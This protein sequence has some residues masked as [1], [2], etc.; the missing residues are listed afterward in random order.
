MSTFTRLLRRVR[1]TG[2][3]PIG[4]ELVPEGLRAVQLEQ[5]GAELALVA[6]LRAGWPD[7]D[8]AV[9]E[10]TPALRRFLRSALGSAGLRGHRVITTLAPSDVKLMV[11]NYQSRGDTDDQAIVSLVSERVRE[12]VA[13]LVIDYSTMRTSGEKHGEKSALVAVARRETV[14]ERLESLRACGLQVDALEIAPGAVRRLIGRA[15][16]DDPDENALAF[17]C[18]TGRSELLVLWGRRFVLHREVDLG[19][20]DVIEA[21]GKALSLDED[22]AAHLLEGA[23]HSSEVGGTLREVLKPT[24]YGLAEQVNQA[25]IYAASQTHG[26]PIHCV[27][28]LGVPRRWP[29]VAELLAQL[30]ELPVRPVEPLALFE[31]APGRPPGRAG[32]E[33]AVAAGLALRGMI[34]DA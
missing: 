9:R 31:P 2:L 33:L 27:R 6:S 12:P 14:I 22:E 26:A 24:L 20:H 5:R 17:H 4:L 16:R 3:G 30:L 28:L 15:T 10:S 8:P 21:V 29:A 13:E 34:Q 1:P 32:D 19:A 7:G 25:V 23:S 11:L 18:Q